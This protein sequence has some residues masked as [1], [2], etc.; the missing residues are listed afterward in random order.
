M[1]YLEIL[2]KDVDVN[3]FNILRFDEMFFLLLLMGIKNVNIFFVNFFL[4]I[5]R[6]SIYK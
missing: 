2:F 3:I 4:L 6:L 5:C 1:Y